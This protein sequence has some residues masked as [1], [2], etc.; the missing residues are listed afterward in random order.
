MPGKAKRKKK[1]QRN[2]SA[3]YTWSSTKKILS[4][5]GSKES[6]FGTPL[7]QNWHFSA[8]F[9][10]IPHRFLTPRCESRAHPIRSDPIASGQEPPQGGVL[11]RQRIQLWE[12][13]GAQLDPDPGGVQWLHRFWFRWTSLFETMQ[14]KLAFEPGHLDGRWNGWKGSRGGKGCHSDPSVEDEPHKSVCF[15]ARENFQVPGSCLAPPKPCFHSQTRLRVPKTSEGCPSQTTKGPQRC[16][17]FQH[18]AFF[19]LYYKSKS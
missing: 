10:Q 2:S 9:G 13:L 8:S 17:L 14:R 4:P 1:E 12:A 5:H 3:P 7:H 18:P 11:G 16:H 19:K 6:H 15:L